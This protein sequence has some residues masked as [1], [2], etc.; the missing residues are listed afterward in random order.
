MGSNNE[1]TNVKIKKYKQKTNSNEDNKCTDP[2]KKKIKTEN[3]YWYQVQEFV[4]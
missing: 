4:I 1:A 2:K 3:K